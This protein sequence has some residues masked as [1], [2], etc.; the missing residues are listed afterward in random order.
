MLRDELQEAQAILKTFG[1]LKLPSSR[2]RIKCATESR[3]NGRLL[4][5]RSK[6]FNYEQIHKKDAFIGWHEDNMPIK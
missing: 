2:K 1:V 6:K 4:D 5:W 3:F